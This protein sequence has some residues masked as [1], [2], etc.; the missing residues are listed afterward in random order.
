MVLTIR[1][2]QFLRDGK[3]VK[4]WGVRVASGTSSTE[5]TGQLIAQLDD[6]KAH[7]INAITVFYQGSSGGSQDPFSPDGKQIRPDH[8]ERMERILREC[9]RRGLAVIVGIF[10]QHAPFGLKDAAAVE[11]AV[12]TVTTSLRPFRNAVLNIANEQNSGGYADSR[13][14]YDFRDPQRIIDLCRVCRG[15]D[16][17]RLVGG[18]G[19]DH[20]K[21]EIIGR[22]PD[23]DVLLFDTAGPDRD[24]DSGK[25]YDRFVAAGVT[26][27]PIV[28]VEQFG[29]WTKQ[30]VPPG[31]YPES[32]KQFHTRYA[33]AAGAR[34][35]LSV[36]FHSNPW[37][38]APSLG[39]FSLRFDLGGQG[40]ANDPGVRW[41]FDY[42]KRLNAVAT[43]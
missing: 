10:Y 32:A 2:D 26:G 3:P 22:S 17:Q 33:D 4:L 34:R 29:G 5:A 9:D 35:G 20:S 11:Q 39:K 41:Y 30:F 18:G 21:N 12:K 19:Y 23:V 31:V 38:Q 27:K 1:D 13:A 40:T 25:L 43:P 16:P 8:Q 24:P 37:F 6:Y 15:T 42:V 28:N 14:I 7:G 36:F